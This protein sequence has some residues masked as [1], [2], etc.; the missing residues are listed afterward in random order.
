MSTTVQPQPLPAYDAVMAQATGENFPVAPLLLGRYRRHLLALYGFA[1]CVDD[2]GDEA[3][4]DRLALLGAIEND[5]TGLYAGST[6]RYPVMRELA[7][8]VR[9]CD[10]PQEPFR[11]LVEANRQDQFVH[12]YNTFDELLGYCQLSAAPVG[13]LVLHVF[14]AATRR[15]I[16]LSDR[17]CWALQVIE[18]L[19][20]VAEDCHRGRVYLPQDELTRAGCDIDELR[21]SSASPRLRSVVARLAERSHALLE[22]GSPLVGELRGRASFAVGGFIAGGQAT[23]AAIERAGYDVLGSRPKK[24]RREFATAAWRLLRNR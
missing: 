5:L 12:R 6:P 13:E 22:A 20:D 10:L 14:G 24:T 3:A 16:E 1:R 4:G 18:H 15:R 8:T 2:S 23:L 19:Q 17:V 9:E 11:R 7:R 21:A